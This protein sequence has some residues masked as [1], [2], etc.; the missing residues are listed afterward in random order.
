MADRKTIMAGV[1]DCV[2]QEWNAGNLEKARSLERFYSALEMRF[3]DELGER[4]EPAGSAEP[5]R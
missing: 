2:V 1:W 5:D 4:P 3:A